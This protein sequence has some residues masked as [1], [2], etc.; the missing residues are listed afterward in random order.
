MSSRPF[1]PASTSM[2]PQAGFNGLVQAAQGALRRRP[3]IASQCS[4]TQQAPPERGRMGACPR[5]S[6]PCGM[7]PPPGAAPAAPASRGPVTPRVLSC[8]TALLPALCR[9]RP[10]SPRAWPLT[11]HRSSRPLPP[12]APCHER[13]SRPRPTPPRRPSAVRAA[14][15]RGGD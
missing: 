12:L 2:V 3:A 6:R 10:P 14:R 13:L 8:A 9:P 5:P 7:A 1:K 11:Q 4:S 15:E